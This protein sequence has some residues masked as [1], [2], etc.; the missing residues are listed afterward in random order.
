MSLSISKRAVLLFAS[1]A[2]ISLSGHAQT[3]MN[4]PAA[5]PSVAE[6]NLALGR[7]D[8]AVRPIDAFQGCETADAPLAAIQDP[9]QRI[10]TAARPVDPISNREFVSFSL[11]ELDTQT[12]LPDGECWKRLDG[13]WRQDVTISLDRSF[14]PDGWGSTKPE[15]VMLANGTYTTPAHITVDPSSNSNAYLM[16]RDALSFSQPVRYDAVDKTDLSDVLIRNG[17]RKTYQARGNTGGL[18]AELTVDVTRSGYVR[19]KIGSETF[20]RPRPG[21]AKS[22]W[23][24]Q[25]S[26]KDPFMI[27]FTMEN[28]IASRRGYDVIT[29]NPNRLMDNPKAEVFARTERGYAI[30]ERRIVPLGMRLVKEEMQ[31]MVYYTELVSS[32]RDIQNMQSSNFGNSTRFGISGSA[33]TSKSS[34]NNS[35]S[36][37]V[38]IE[39]GYGWGSSSAKESFESLRESESVAKETGYM[40]FRKYALVA[41]HPYIQLSD[42]FIDAVEDAR[43]FADYDALIEKFGTHYPYAVSYGASGQLTQTITSEAYAREKSNSSSEESNSNASFVVGNSNS[44]S[45]VN[46][47]TGTSLREVNEY[48]ERSFDAVGGN[49]SWSEA[50]FAAGDAHYPILADLRPL[51]D[52]LNPMN[53]PNEPEIYDRVRIELA[54]RIEA[55]LNANSVLSDVSLLPEVEPIQSWVLRT[56]MLACDSAG[57]EP[58]SNLEIAGKLTL[59]RSSPAQYA[60]FPAMKLIDIRRKGST[61]ASTPVRNVNCAR[62]RDR[63]VK[64]RTISGTAE[65]LARFRFRVT[66][67]LEELDYAGPLD[68]DDV[69]KGQS[70]HF[71][72]PIGRPVGHVEK[73]AY[74][75]PPG[76]EGT[77]MG[78]HWTLTRTQ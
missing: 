9:R 72:L 7:P 21:T 16:V 40:R 70:G 63:L 44:Y 13:V 47:R 67:N 52:L 43:R 76:N 27:G 4:Q 39:A 66:V 6:P 31:G 26:N 77:H 53:F 48:G 32:E 54:R 33:S 14:T 69:I 62:G 10:E 56:S 3:A 35:R 61:D 41:D 60:S 49:G 22:D 75:L 15:L 8:Q 58:N 23:D 50:G 36:G 17:A 57:S 19:M 74:R 2:L 38:N 28:L 20:V 73:Q 30:D 18:G 12:D 71:K 78:L 55:Y 1:T 65:N 5:G 29:Q 42:S 34:D 68:P 25:I 37:S 51:D 59:H 64:A 45:S 46:Q 11:D 24:S